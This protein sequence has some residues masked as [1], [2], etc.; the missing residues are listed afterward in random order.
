[1]N[2]QWEA[3]GAGCPALLIFTGP[4]RYVSPAVYGYTPAAPTWNF[5]AVHA[6][7][8]LS[9]LPPGEPTLAVIRATVTALEERLG[10]GWDMTASLPYFDRLL[11]GVGA[12]EM[13]VE[14][15]DAMFKLS[16]EQTPQVRS[17]VAADIAG[18]DCGHHRALARMMTRAATP[19]R[20]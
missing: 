3:I 15:L 19:N 16:Q 4:D 14:R 20:D 8:W 18:S 1:M 9:P 7:G 12:F 2:P 10:A 11:P 5:T 13:R 17:R 6:T